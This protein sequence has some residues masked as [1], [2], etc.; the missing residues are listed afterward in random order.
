MADYTREQLIE[1]L[2]RADAAGD[3]SAA[4]AIAKRI[5]GLQ[6]QSTPDQENETGQLNRALLTAQ[7]SG[8]KEEARRIGKQIQSNLNRQKQSD[9]EN[10]SLLSKVGTGIADTIAGAVR[11]A[12]GIGATLIR[13]FESAAENQQRRADIDR[14]MAQL[15]GAD[16]N[17]IA[18]GAGKLGAEIAGTAGVGGLLGK[19]ISAIPGASQAVPGF[20]R[21]IQTGGFSAP[22]IGVRALGGAATGA[23]SAAAVDPTLQSAGIGAGLGAALPAIGGVIG[24]MLRSNATPEMLDAIQ[25]A[26]SS[27]Y[28]IPPT[29]AGG[30]ALL[31]TIEGMAGKTV[32]SQKASQINQNVTNKLAAR[33]IGL[34][35]NTPITPDALKSVRAEASKA[36]DDLASLPV[37]PAQKANPLMGTPE[38]PGFNPKEALQELRQARND[39][40]AWFKSYGRTADPTA[41]AN[42]LSA[43]NKAADLEDTFAQYAQSLG[44]PEVVNAMQNARTLIAK[45]HQ[46]ENALN[47]ET[48]TISAKIL[49]KASASGKPLTDELADIASFAGRF[50]KAANLPETIGGTP[51]VS[52]LD[53]YGA[54]L[55][56]PAGLALLTGRLGA[57]SAVTSDMLQNALM[58]NGMNT[59]KVGNFL[60]YLSRTSPSMAANIN[61][62][63]R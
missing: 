2:R 46:V 42:A 4:K 38:I 25:K 62:S 49:A 18:Y 45:T 12:G 28:V 36:Y 57:R 47:P 9:Y 1:A 63:N 24:N 59:G 55:L 21:A 51:T 8:D 37:L 44:R 61:E 40:S 16:T 15:L 22:N 11:G 10:S 52:P 35:E 39:A 14:G 26:R 7:K 58:K 13:P 29:Q 41:Q 50:P 34:P 60:R 33:A 48:G 27:G 32:S 17:S 31:Q 30:N 20:I 43:A 54:G 23:A 53:V 3:A 5:Q 56:G 6:P 19:G